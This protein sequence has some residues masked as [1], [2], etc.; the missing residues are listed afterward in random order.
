MAAESET[1]KNI[2]VDGIALEVDTSRLEDVRFTYALGKV[3]AGETPDAEKLVWYARMLDALFGDK[4]YGIMCEV[5]GDGAL[6]AGAWS[7]FYMKV[8]EAVGQ[9]N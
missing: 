5:A 2:E 7:D 8:L 4:A 1:I 3:S 9:K 6:T